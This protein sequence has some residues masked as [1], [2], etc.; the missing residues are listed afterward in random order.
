MFLS[1]QRQIAIPQA[2]HQRLAGTLALLWGN[3]AFEL[4]P[5]PFEAFVLGVGLHDRAYG[6]MDTFA[7]GGLPE[8]DWLAL[9]QK[10]FDAAWPDPVADAITKLHLQRLVGSAPSDA[11]QAWA[12]SMGELIRAHLERH[13]LDP[14][15]F[16]RIDRITDLCDQIAFDLC[17]EAPAQGAVR[18]FPRNNAHEEVSVHYRI[19][20][21]AIAVDPWPFRVDAHEGYLIGYQLDGYPMRQEPALLHY[22]LTRYSP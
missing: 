20:N 11:R 5:V 18:I 17:F 22:R 6:H 10:G 16:A 19:D 1:K 4:P 7:I 2:E 15:V 21:G 12:S 8:A 3:A 13:Q 9:T 14:A